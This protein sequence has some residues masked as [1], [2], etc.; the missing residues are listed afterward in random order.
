MS[1]APRWAAIALATLALTLSSSTVA[2]AATT[3][4][5]RSTREYTMHENAYTTLEVRYRCA[6]G[7]QAS[8]YAELWQGGTA[9]NPYSF[10]STDHR[11]AYNPPLVCD[12]TKR[13]VMLG[14][15]LGG[16][17]E[18]NGSADYYFLQDTA[19]GFG[20]ANVTVQLTDHTSGKVDT[21]LDRVEV[22]SR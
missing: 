21:D 2:L 13:T 11:D 1:S 6:A 4:Q 3:P 7:H 9:D 16:Y 15:I 8:L 22:V 20:R 10:F 19:L 17:S 14:L 5:V 18:E 12:G